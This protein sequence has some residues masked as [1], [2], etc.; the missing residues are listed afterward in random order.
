MAN[1]LTEHLSIS[2]RIFVA[3]ALAGVSVP[4]FS[5]HGVAG[6]GAAG[7]RGPGAPVESA[8]SATLPA[9]GTLAYLKL[10][11]AKYETYD[12]DPANPESDYA[13]YWM[14]GVGYGVASWF[15][16]YLFLPYHSKVDEPGGLDSRGFADVSVMG[17]VG[18]KYD[19]GWRLIPDNES[20]DDLEDWHFTLFGGFT[21]PTGDA[22]LRLDDGSIDAG[23][24]TGFGK[25]SWSLGLTA[26]K[27]LSPQW[28][29]NQELST[30]GFQEYEYDDGNR[31]KFGQEIRANSALIYRAYTDLDRK[32]RVDLSMEAQYLHLG[33]DRTNGVDEKATGG[34]MIYA[35]PGV[36]VYWD[37]ISAVFGLKSPIWT[38]L[39]EESQ[40]QGG[41]GSEDY[42]LIFTFSSLF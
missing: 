15:S 37:N 12:S 1:T 18:F 13:N 34:D 41:E 23:K 7:L 16:A 30:I 4:C 21:L 2:R 17:Q 6:L 22:D 3:C 27:M 10:D 20:L 39:N 38:E 35:L 14:A 29:F 26:T 40:Q 32:L 5:H 11:H 42:R 8:T 19:E 31:T 28:T 33:R 36:R 9:G 25:P 24:S